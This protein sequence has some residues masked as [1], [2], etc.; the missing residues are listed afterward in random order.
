LALYFFIWQRAQQRIDI[1]A[2][3]F[4]GIVMAVWATLFLESWK[5]KQNSYSADWGMV[6]YETTE[7]IRAEYLGD[8]MR[9]PRSGKMTK[10][11][12]YIQTILRTLLSQVVVWSLICV[13]LA[14]V[15][16]IFFLRE[17]LSSAGLGQAGNVITSIIQA[18]Q[19]QVLNY[20]YS[21]VSEKLNDYEN[22]RTSSDY[23]NGLILKSFLFKFINS[24]NSL[25]YIAFFKKYDASTGCQADDPNCL[26][27]L[28][29][30]LAIL[31]GSALVIN[32]TIEILLPYLMTKYAEKTNRAVDSAGTEK[33]RSQWEKEFE[34]NPYTTFDDFDEM[35][36]Q[37][38]Y[39]TLFVVAFP[40]APL[41]ALINNYVEIRLD[42][43]KMLSLSQRPK[44]AGALGIGTWLGILE[45]LSFISIITNTIIVV[46]DTA[47]VQGWA[48]D[49]LYNLAWTFFIIEH[50]IG[51][52]K[53]V[54]GYAVD[55]VPTSVREHIERQKYV[56]DVLI[57]DIAEEAEEL[58]E[59][60][61]VD[62]TIV[63]NWK[64]DTASKSAPASRI[65]IDTK[66]SV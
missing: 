40:I 25:F 38:G 13:V 55:D 9:D 46:F 52:I 8:K 57:N 20:V 36:V 53:V 41:A 54:I 47:I 6:N 42:A 51:V 3:P 37:Y 27:E 58:R 31:F 1:D 14:A 19:I 64:Y 34:L 29:V 30:Q 63:E 32:N 12:P 18:I 62:E 5:R 16:S 35:V 7:G 10:I 2:L 15:V 45:V 33:M 59:A 48:Y 26:T 22:H 24:Y 21:L 50:V 23:E 17:V 65:G 66:D 56:V 28:Q 44:P 61:D 11:F 49:D 4:F 39:V 43:K 60:E